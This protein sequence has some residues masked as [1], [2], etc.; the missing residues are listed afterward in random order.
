MIKKGELNS[1]EGIFFPDTYYFSKNSSFQV[2][3]DTFINRFNDIFVKEYQKLKQP[4]LSFYKTLI[5]A[6]IIEKEAG[7][8]SEMPIIS[9]VFHNRLRKKMHLASC[10]TVGYAMGQPR[11]NH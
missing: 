8:V 2:V 9:G 4:K 5:L 6:S 1:F 3:Y 11:K 7:T 10:P